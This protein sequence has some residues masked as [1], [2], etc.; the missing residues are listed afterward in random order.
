M[1]EY[2]LTQNQNLLWIGQQIN[3]K[4]PMYNMIMSY[5]IAGPVSFSDFCIAFDHVVAQ[6]D[7]LRTVFIL[8]NKIPI[9]RFLPAIDYEV[10]F[11]DFSGHTHPRDAYAQWQEERVVQLFNLEK[12]LFDCAL[13][14]IAEDRYI[15]Y[16]NQHHLITDGWSTAVLFKQVEEAYKNSKAETTKF[17]DPES[18]ISFLNFEQ[19]TKQKAKFDST[20]EYWENKRLTFPSPPALYHLT[21]LKLETNSRRLHKSLGRERTA[22]INAL[23]NQEGIKGWSADLTLYNIFLTALFSFVYRISDQEHLVIGSPTHNRVKKSFRDA[24]GYFVETFPLSTIVEEDETFASLLKKVQT[25]SNG[26]LKHAQVGASSADL[27]RDFNV[28]FN[29]THA[30]NTSFD[31]AAVSTSWVHSG[32]TDPRHHIRFHVH[33]FDNT[34][35]IQLY[36]DLNTGIFNAEMQELVPQHFLHLLDAFIEDPSQKIGTAALITQTEINQ[37]ALWN[38]TKVDFPEESLLTKFQ[39]QVAQSPHA[40]A[41]VYEG[42]SL[43][44]QA[45]DEKS[46]QMARFLQ[47]KGADQNDV[48]AISMDRSLE[49]MISIYGIIKL[50][51]S[52][53]PVD[54]CTP[55]ERLQFILQDAN[56]KALCY[57]H[58]GVPASILEQFEC[59]H[60]ADVEEQISQFDKTR[61]SLSSSPDDLAYIIY[62]SGSTGEPKGV[63]CHHEG[64]CNRL[65]WMNRQ[66]PISSED[67]FLQKTPITFD[68]SVWELFWPLQHGATLVIES[69]QGHMNPRK[70]IESI[71]QHQV[72]HIHFVPSMLNVFNQAEGIEQC[73]SLKR[74][75]CSGEALS[76]PIVKET[77]AKLPA[78][79]HNLYGPTEACVDVSSW[80]CSRDNL[81][82]PIPIGKPVAN[83]RLYILDQALQPLP[84]GLKGELFIAGTQVAKGYLNR[85]LLTE[86][87]FV[88]DIF[89]E[90][91]GEKMYR[92]GDLARYRNDGTIEYHGRLD[93]QIK[94]RG[95]R[96]EL[97]EIESNIENVPSISQAVVAVDD[98]ENL[99]AY[100]IGSEISDATIITTLERH[101]PAYM[102]PQF[103]MRLE[104]FEHLSNGKVDR[105]KLPK[106]K[107]VEG[108]SGSLVNSNVEP[109]VT[110]IE[111]IVHAVWTEVLGIEAIGIHQNFIRIG[112]N[113]LDAISITSRLE[114]ML[115][116]EVSII[117]VF[118]YPTISSY[119]QNVEEVIIELLN[120]ST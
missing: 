40:V 77:Y 111:E 33:D 6:N 118:N 85:P 34:G 35:Q 114:T 119:A 53:L 67:V 43:T 10:V 74:I 59:Y 106:H 66:Y 15:W 88:K 79:I 60:V 68:V 72:S 70:L 63:K 101:L 112:G 45:L 78:E 5:E 27:N 89:S 54:V 64:I 16:I 20:L 47:S 41:L 95:L 3:P 93:N 83:T 4:S 103:Y 49:M 42:Q 117:D 55:E 62:T 71:T 24:L 97:G 21:T 57:N 31:G 92:T 76:L 56:V 2:P 81:S 100:Y 7:A 107:T 82:G 30:Q 44:Y 46:S 113:S 120:A 104:S 37:I 26:F 22:K 19:E 73:T 39:R 109:P 84:I 12:C 29:Y 110:E 91:P 13:I 61:L 17:I 14:K 48:I 38:D 36:F 87:R 32:H 18:Y 102:I 65:Q 90:N 115:E 96:I 52:Y 99:V 69:P 11:E 28:F 98:Q 80:H 1:K 25:E 105:R 23:A 58:R 50:G 51:A 116:L 86:D 8:K 75:F 9:Q 94:L 108:L